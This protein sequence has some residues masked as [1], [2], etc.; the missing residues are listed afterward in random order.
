MKLKESNIETIV[1][2]DKKAKQFRVSDSKV[3]Y[4]ILR[5]K[6]YKDPIRAVCREISANSRDANREAENNEVPIEIEIIESI[7]H[8]GIGGDLAICFRDCGIG[9]TPDRMDDIFIV[10]GESSKR[11]TNTQVGGYG[12]GAKTPFAYSDTFSI[13]TVCDVTETVYDP[14]DKSGETFKEIQ[15]TKRM[16]YFYVAAIDKEEKGTMYLF[17]AEETTE[18]TGT[19]ITVPIKKMDRATFEVACKYYTKCWDVV[20]LYRNFASNLY[21]DGQAEPPIKRTR[22]KYFDI[23]TENTLYHSVK[24]VHVDGIPYHHQGSS[25]HPAT[26]VVHVGNGVLELSGSREDIQDKP[27]NYKITRELFKKA[28]L[29]ASGII[30]DM[31]KDAKNWKQASYMYYEMTQAPITSENMVIKTLLS[32]AL[33]NSSVPIKWNGKTLV[34]PPAM[35]TLYPYIRTLTEFNGQERKTTFP[36]YNNKRGFF[37]YVSTMRKHSK[38]K[39]DRPTAYHIGNAS[40]ATQRLNTIL[41]REDVAIIFKRI[42][43][44]EWIRNNHGKTQED[45]DNQA[46]REFMMFDEFFRERE[47]SS[48]LPTPYSE[49]TAKARTSKVNLTYRKYNAQRAG[50][51]DDDSGLAYSS[52]SDD[53][54][55]KTYK[56]EKTIVVKT[57]PLSE[58]TVVDFN[59]M[60][61]LCGLVSGT[62]WQVLGANR[63]YGTILKM[64]GI[65]PE[66]YMSGLVQADLDRIRKITL[67]GLLKHDVLALTRYNKKNGLAFDEEDKAILSKIGVVPDGNLQAAGR[68]IKK[69]SS[70]VPQK[71]YGKFIESLDQPTQAEADEAYYILEKYPMLTLLDLVDKED[72]EAKIE[73]KSEI[74]KIND[75]MK[76]IQKTKQD[77]R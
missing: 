66:Q 58:F 28:T 22:Y 29:E 76:L 32:L 27:E 3:I 19:T 37:E 65:T 63:S 60:S 23:I 57:K 21:P 40:S 4:D 8:L 59:E 71:K 45:Y 70:P 9:I 36:K 34:V 10:Y 35:E 2:G 31:L 13:K 69:K 67:Q 12:L 41:L 52:V 47:I 72:G 26:V 74:E 48:E 56:F 46:K 1:I 14:E 25:S 49:K 54:D 64:G 17:K 33:E 38:I 15:L 75:Y 53:F 68:S 73:D 5:N 62:A 42:E 77:V 18:E 30:R 61:F 20:P 6:L 11:E 51:Y 55:Q 44:T 7:D 50:N 24:Y 16:K 39:D 43:F